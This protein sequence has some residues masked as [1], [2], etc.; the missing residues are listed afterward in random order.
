MFLESDR[1][2]QLETELRISIHSCSP[3][4]RHDQEAKD[5]SVEVGFGQLLFFF[6]TAKAL[7]PV[8]SRENG[9]RIRSILFCCKVA[10]GIQAEDPSLSLTGRYT[11][12]AI[13]RSAVNRPSLVPRSPNPID[14][15]GR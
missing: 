8:V 4:I 12:S 13:P 2:H 1:Q 15:S 5:E 9:F 3:R 7:L 11:R 14:P 6:T 10:E